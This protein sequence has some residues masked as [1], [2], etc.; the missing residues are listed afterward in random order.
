MQDC[1]LTLN[2]ANVHAA[3]GEAAKT[4]NMLGCADSEAGAREY[5]NILG[6]KEFVSDFT[7]I[8]SHAPGF[9]ELI[10]FLQSAEVEAVKAALLRGEDREANLQKLRQLY[11]DLPDQ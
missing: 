10:G 7:S 3:V 4:M 9:E 6:A 11:E 8:L 5:F 1:F 2:T